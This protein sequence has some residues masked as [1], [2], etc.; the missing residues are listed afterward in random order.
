M[1]GEQV[2]L[3]QAVVVCLFSMVV[4]FIVLLVISYLIDLCAYLVR[5]FGR[6]PAAKAA[7]PAPAPA[8]APARDDSADAVLV[9]AAVAAYLGKNSDEFVVRSICRVTGGETLWSQASRKDSLQ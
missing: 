3:S 9:A 2:T 4:V 1:F 5:R 6:A 8:P 7:S